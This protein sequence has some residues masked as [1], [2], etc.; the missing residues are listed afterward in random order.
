MFNH[1]TL[2]TKTH[3]YSNG[4]IEIDKYTVLSFVQLILS[5][6]A[7]VF[8]LFSLFSPDWWHYDDAFKIGLLTF[9]HQGQC[10]YIDSTYVQYIC[11]ST[12]SISITFSVIAFFSTLFD[13]YCHFEYIT[14]TL[15]STLI[16]F[17]ISFTLPLNII[18]LSVYGVGNNQLCIYD[19][20]G[21]RT[22]A[23]NI[24]HCN[25]G[26]SYILLIS[27]NQ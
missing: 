1:T 9:C 12:L 6:L 19:N 3:K 27:Y 15:T 14:N 26:I 18:T 17:F 16:L 8:S 7:V 11:I 10:F 13:M 23:T 5:S 4:L 25:L 21:N 20:H 2:N 22:L 24:T